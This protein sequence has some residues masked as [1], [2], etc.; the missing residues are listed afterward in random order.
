MPRTQKAFTASSSPTP[1]PAAEE[2]LWGLTV[3]ERPAFWFYIPDS[4]A[5][6][7]S[8][9]FVLQD[10]QNNELYRTSFT[11]SRSSSGIAKFSLPDAAAPLEIGKLYRW[12]FLIYCESEE[13]ESFVFVDGWVQRVAVEESIASQLE[14][15]APRDRAILYAANGIWHDAVT[16]L[17]EERLAF[18]DDTAFATDW[19][20]L[21]QSAGF[22]AIARQPFSPCCTV[23]R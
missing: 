18:P 20:G 8:V 2:F 13:R 12:F 5:S 6:N 19:A 15:A 22:E 1:P 3:S 7:S 23:D 16:T 9:D 14:K 10:D 21:L 4:F 17:A 11:V